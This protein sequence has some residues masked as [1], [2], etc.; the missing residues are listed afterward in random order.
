MTLSL[1]LA[2]LTP[3]AV[4]PPLPPVAP[5]T[6]I[7]EEQSFDELEGEFEEAYDAWYK[8][9]RAAAKEDRSRVAKENPKAV[10]IARFLELAEI[11]PGTDDGLSALS[12]VVKNGTAK[13]RDMS[14]DI[15]ERE[16]LDH[17]KLSLVCELLSD[18]SVSSEAFL[19]SVMKAAPSDFVRASA[20]YGL[21]QQLRRQATIAERLADA[22]AD[23][24]DYYRSRYGEEVMSR[25]LDADVEERGAEI[26]ELLSSIVAAFEGPDFKHLLKR[27]DGDLFEIQ[28]LGIGKLAP[29][30]EAEDLDGVTFKLSDYR[31]KVVVLDFWGN[32]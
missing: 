1:V 23:M 2:L 6:L 27:V 30:I 7:A 5:V 13:D 20:T 21:T 24:V 25:M 16:F 32:W 14:L 19:R 31:G 9:Y 10:F 3:S 26:E 8:R 12:W 28:K 11:G 29:E 18:P 17:K 22:P 15:I 4:P